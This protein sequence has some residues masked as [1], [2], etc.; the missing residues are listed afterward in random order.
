[1]AL[2][3]KTWGKT[4]GGLSVQTLKKYGGSGTSVTVKNSEGVI[5]NVYKGYWVDVTITE[6]STNIANNTSSVTMTVKFNWDTDSGSGRYNLTT[7]TSCLRI[8][9]GDSL[10]APPSTAPSSSSEDYYEDFY[11][12]QNIVNESSTKIK[13]DFR[14]ASGYTVCNGTTYTKTIDVPHNVDGSGKLAWRVWFWSSAPTSAVLFN[15][16]GEM[17]LTSIPRVYISNGSAW[18]PGVPYV[19]DGTTWSQG[20]IKVSNGTNWLP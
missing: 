19:S 10:D 3:T 2:Q 6:N 14:R 15:S 4:T 5:S 1:M 13:W 20:V 9:F 8:G 18:K 16:Y 11:C 17:N 12:V 7:N